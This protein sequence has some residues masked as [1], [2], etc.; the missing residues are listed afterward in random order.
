MRMQ[1]VNSEA[2][3]AIGYDAERQ[4]LDVRY[5]TGSATYR[6]LDVPSGVY[7]ELLSAASVGTYLFPVADWHPACCAFQDQEVDLMAKDIKCSIGG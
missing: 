4:W 1:R 6:Y 5:T 3:K 2:A 7:A